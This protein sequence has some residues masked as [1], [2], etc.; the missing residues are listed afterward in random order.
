MQRF[1][2]F[3]VYKFTKHL[4]TKKMKTL[5]AYFS[6]SG[7][8][9]RVAQVMAEI[10]SADL[11]AIVPQIP[12]S[13]AHLDW[14]DPYSRSSVEMRDLSSRPPI[15]ANLKDANTYEVIFLGFPIWW[16][17]APTIINTFLDTYNFANKVVIPFA[18]SDETSIAK[19]QEDLR[20][21]YPN[22][23]WKPGKLI[24]RVYRKQLEA[25]FKELGIL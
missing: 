16:S 17:T 8:T 11:F 1:G 19:S 13:K 10:A 2:F 18:T 9:E 14:L 12:Y 25:W 7:V 4:I 20:K 15:I 5:V 3:F 23:N 24:I 21:S 6:A 22:L